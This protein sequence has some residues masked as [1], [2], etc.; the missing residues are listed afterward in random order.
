MP[1]DRDSR[2]AAIEAA[3]RDA[4]AALLKRSQSPAQVLALLSAAIDGAPAEALTPR[5][6]A[7]AL[8]QTRRERMLED[9]RHGN[10]NVMKIARRYAADCRDPV[11]TASLARQLRRWRKNTDNVR[12]GRMKKR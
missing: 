4:A 11:E 8:R 9:L 10:G 6:R 2:A 3:V 12:P 5:E 7:A 1:A